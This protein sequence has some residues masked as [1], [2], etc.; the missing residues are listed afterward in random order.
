MNSEWEIWCKQQNNPSPHKVATAPYAMPGHSK[1]NMAHIDQTEEWDFK[2][3][4]PLLYQCQPKDPIVQRVIDKFQER[5]KA[6]MNKYKVSMQNNPKKLKEWLI[7][8]QEELMD[9]TNYIE[10]VLQ[11][12]ETKE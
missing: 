2:P 4:K 8:L 10:R 3:H 5:S 11:E 12:L 6:G 1:N 9:A 7:D